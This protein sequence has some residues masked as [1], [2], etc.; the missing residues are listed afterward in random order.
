MVS[1]LR[2][3]VAPAITETALVRGVLIGTT[4]LFLTVFLLAPLALIFTIAFGQGVV[5]Y[6]HSFTDHDT[7][8]AIRLT[9]IAAAIRFRRI[10][11]S[12]SRRRGR[13]ASLSSSERAS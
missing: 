7:L 11:S 1:A 8:S 9:L 6:F 13:S 4:V 3:R 12:A 10:W 2:A 5:A